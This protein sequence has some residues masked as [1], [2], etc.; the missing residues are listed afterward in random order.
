[1]ILKVP[2]SCFSWAQF[3]EIQISVIAENSLISFR[4]RQSSSSRR[5]SDNGKGAK[6]HFDGRYGPGV[7]LSEKG[8]S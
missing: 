7:G 2:Y 3:D 4:N 8:G 1:M 6:L 5:K